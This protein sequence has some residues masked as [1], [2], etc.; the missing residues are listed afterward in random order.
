MSGKTKVEVEVR[1]RDDVKETLTQVAANL[2]EVMKLLAENRVL[3]LKL[4][5]EHELLEAEPTSGREV[6]DGAEAE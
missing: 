1:L 4:F 2:V 6:S 3:L 5:E